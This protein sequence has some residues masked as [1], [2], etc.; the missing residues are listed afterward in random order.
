MRTCSLATLVFIGIILSCQQQKLPGKDAA[1]MFFVSA[2]GNDEHDG[3]RQSPWKT[4]S[5]VNAAE[6]K[7]GS[8][9]HFEG[10]ATFNGTIVV[11]ADEA[12]TDSAPIVIT[13][14]GAGAAFINSG[15]DAGFTA[16]H[17]RYIQLRNM[18]FIGAGRKDGN[19]THGVAFTS[20]SEI[21]ADSIE[22]S[23]YRNA[24]LAVYRSAG[25]RITNVYAH[26][27][28]FAGIYAGG[29]SHK[30]EC[31]DIYI[32][33]CR[34]ENNPGDPTNLTNHS[35][36]GIL[37]GFCRNVM[38]EY[39]AATNNGWDMPRKGNGPVG[40]W[41]FEA[42][43]VTIQH[44]I[45]YRNK[46]SPGAADGGGFDLDGGVTN[47]IIQYCLS[48]DNEGS[49]FGLFQYAGASNWYNNTVRFNISE[50]DGKVSAAK[51]GVFVWNSSD[52]S[53]ELSKL[54]FHNNVIYN[55]RGSAISYERQSENEGFRF[56]NNIFVAADTMILGHY[57]SGEFVGNNWWSIKSGFNI[58][59][60]RD[61]ASWSRQK[62]KE[63]INGTQVGSNVDPGFL[64]PG[65][66]NV[67]D[68]TQLHLLKNYS[69]PVG[70]PL[71]TSGIDAKAVFSIDPGTKD[72]NGGKVLKS[73]V[74]VAFGE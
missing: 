24:G 48:Y 62:D 15:N 4:I 36:N 23:G 61:F 13:S 3:S 7:P 64:N 19:T 49:G 27:N 1:K 10:G 21:I 18:K 8:I 9:V 42:D 59:G 53:K 40:I 66:A 56:F 30:S 60:N 63:R 37:A 5:R 26:D 22:V 2:T 20:C 38:I 14:Y 35:G 41:C 25:A 55:E 67:E 70:S 68:P 47:S 44:C 52:N 28:G 74:G 45:A 39:C 43:S 69:L 29:E 54:N 6:L 50:N 58:S 16:D 34:A 57:M 51:A 71:L 11:T 33:Y 65:N 72:F 73:G 31:S 32:G 17:A 12:G 46:T